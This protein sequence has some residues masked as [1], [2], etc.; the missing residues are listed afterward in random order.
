M[1]SLQARFVGKFYGPFEIKDVAVR[2]EGV[3]NLT[4]DDER[5]IPCTEKA[6]IAIVSDEKK[7]HNHIRSA[8]FQVLV[9]K[10]VKLM[11]EYDVPVGDVNA[12]LQDIAREVDNHFARATNFLW[13][14]NDQRY[15]PGFNPMEDITLIMAHEV[16]DNIIDHDTGGDTITET[17]GN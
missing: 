11:K 6:L 2:S 14:Q 4:L 3:F 16:T 12:L 8:R 10:I 15:V 9:P 7:D 5:M 13:T 17:A 1:D